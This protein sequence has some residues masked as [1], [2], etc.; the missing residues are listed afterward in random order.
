[1]SSQF[2]GEEPIKMYFSEAIHDAMVRHVGPSD[3]GVEQ[4]LT[5]M[6][7]EFLRMDGVYG[8]KDKFGKPVNSVCEML[9]EGDIRFNA[10][11]FAREREVH[12]HIGDFLLFWSGLFP[13]YLR[14]L[15]SPVGK[16][17]L[18]D[19]VGQGR[20]SYHV[21]STFEFEPY[22]EEAKVLRKL[23]EEFEGYQYGLGLVRAGF[24]GF[25]RQGWK[26][27]FEA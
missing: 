20:M 13:E 10:D 16:D 15:K 18:L 11:S 6:L 7:V 1:M 24:E 8:L 17:A 22:G 26:N 14:H 19:P 21:A 27:G 4:Y 9:R 23:S 3:P 25:R 12:R 5:K 2:S